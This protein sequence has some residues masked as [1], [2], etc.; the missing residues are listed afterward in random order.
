MQVNKCRQLFGL[1]LT[2]KSGGHRPGSNG[3][4]AV[5]YIG[6]SRPRKFCKLGHR[7]G[8]NEQRVTYLAHQNCSFLEAGLPRGLIYIG[9][10]DLQSPATGQQP[11][12]E[13]IKD[14]Q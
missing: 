7:L 8:F 10:Q 3:N 12:S 5:T 2:D 4:H 1:T 14:I 9:K 13:I 6:S 11:G